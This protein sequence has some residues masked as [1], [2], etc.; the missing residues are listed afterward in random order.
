MGMEHAEG[1]A[2]NQMNADGCLN[3][4]QEDSIQR[5][6]I[7]RSGADSAVKRGQPG[8]GHE[9]IDSPKPDGASDGRTNDSSKDKSNAANYLPAVTLKA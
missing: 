7:Q 4:L 2:T 1:N 9:G 5:S 3:K 8:S 6:A